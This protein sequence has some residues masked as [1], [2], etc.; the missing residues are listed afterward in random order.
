MKTST[1]HLRRIQI[2]S[3]GMCAA[4]FGKRCI[5]TW[6]FFSKEDEADRVF[7]LLNKSSLFE[8]KQINQVRSS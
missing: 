5:I 7:V 4:V 1:I 3:G 2:V 6:V 8:E